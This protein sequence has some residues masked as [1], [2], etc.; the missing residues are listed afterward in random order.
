MKK[1][2][3]CTRIF[4]LSLLVISV[5]VP[6]C[7]LSHKIKSVH[8]DEPGEFVEDLS[9]IKHRTEAH[10][11]SALGEEE[12][13]DVKEPLMVVY[14]DDK[15]SSDSL[16]ESNR[17]DESENTE[18]AT[19]G[20]SGIMQMNQHS[21][22]EEVVRNSKENAQSEPKRVQHDQSRISHSQKTSDVKLKEMKDQIIRA[23]VYLSFSPQGSKSHIVKELKMRIK[24]LER[25]MGEVTK[26]SDL[27]RR[28]V[29]KM[30]AMEATL[31]KAS[32]MFPE[33]TPMVKKL[34]A[35]TDSAEEQLRTHKNQV[36]FLEELAGRT[37]PK[38]LHCFSMRLTAEYFA[39][40]PEE[41]EFPNQH[42]LHNPDLYHFAVF[43][44]NILA[45]SVVV[46]ST[47]SSAKVCCFC[48]CS[49]FSSF[50]VPLFVPRLF[51]SFIFIHPFNFWGGLKLVI[52]SYYI[53]F[54]WT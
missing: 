11:V 4:I 41:R 46:N 12:S 10:I 2:H 32:H 15:F 37:T 16:I 50:H 44:D 30:K 36:A 33:C 18:N 8:S 25:V 3:R 17:T 21:Q 43:S 6:I 42:K 5:C 26:D 45:C 53:N 13:E 48:I 39:L 52:C 31:S 9:I 29:Q 51:I 23:K 38:G 24:D 49:F 1:F 35:M 20:E 34:R 19:L 40:M 54:S 22:H 28:A 7:F 27:S 14:K 47:I